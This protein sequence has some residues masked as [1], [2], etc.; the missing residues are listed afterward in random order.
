MSLPPVGGTEARPVVVGGDEQNFQ[1]RLLALEERE[2]RAAGAERLARESGCR[3][4]LDGKIVPVFTLEAEASCASLEGP[5]ALASK[6]ELQRVLLRIRSISDVARAV[7]TEM[8]ML[9]SSRR[10]KWMYGARARRLDQKDEC[11]GEE[12]MC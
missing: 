7:A 3:I 4:S 2:R 9:R 8:V 10:C 5:I 12:E 1:E 6:G 11:L